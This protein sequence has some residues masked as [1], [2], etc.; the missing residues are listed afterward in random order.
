MGESYWNL[1]RGH[2]FSLKALTNT[3]SF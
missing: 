1:E 3:L 2:R